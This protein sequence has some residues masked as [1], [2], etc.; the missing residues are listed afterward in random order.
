MRPYIAVGIIIS[1]AS[2][3]ADDGANAS[4]SIAV[5]NRPAPPQSSVPTGL[6]ASYSAYPEKLVI[7]AKGGWST[8]LVTTNRLR[9]VVPPSVFDPNLPEKLLKE[10]A[11]LERR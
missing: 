5:T 10:A 7:R 3:I 9:L 4:Q 6:S 11:N 8:N 2:L 1:C